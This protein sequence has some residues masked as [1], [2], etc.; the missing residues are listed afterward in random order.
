MSIVLGIFTVALQITAFIVLWKQGKKVG[1]GDASDEIRRL[2][3]E[4]D[5]ANLRIQEVLKEKHLL[6]EKHGPLR[7]ATE[8]RRSPEEPVEEKIQEGISRLKVKPQT[9]AE[10]QDYAKM[11]SIQRRTMSQTTPPPP[12]PRVPTSNFGGGHTTHHTHH[13][14]LPGVVLGMAIHDALASSGDPCVGVPDYTNGPTQQGS[15]DVNLTERNSCV[16]STP[17]YEAP[18][19]SAPSYEPPSCSSSTDYSS[20]STDFGCSDTSSSSSSFGD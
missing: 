2:R 11:S 3:A 15:S 5:L 6:E 9:Q 17:A 18:S 16:D 19:Y 4:R 20:G 10:R 14:H 1:V 8:S 7:P 12:P 13:D